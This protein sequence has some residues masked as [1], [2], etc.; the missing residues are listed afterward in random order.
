MANNGHRLK[1]QN[2]IHRKGQ[3]VRIDFTDTKGNI[4]DGD[5]A[6]LWSYHEPAAGGMPRPI[7]IETG[8]FSKVQAATEFTLNDA[9]HHTIVLVSFDGKSFHCYTHGPHHVG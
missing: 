1:H 3:K 6:I 2:S 8:A 5:H 7:P 4:D 9:G